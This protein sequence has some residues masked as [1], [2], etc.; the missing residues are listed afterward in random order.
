MVPVST[1]D[2]GGILETQARLSV[3]LT[4]KGISNQKRFLGI[5]SR[6]QQCSLTS[7]FSV[8]VCAVERD[9]ALQNIL[10]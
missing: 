1:S 8:T 3:H 7:S 4:K 10:A 5:T 6:Q 2:L 9:G